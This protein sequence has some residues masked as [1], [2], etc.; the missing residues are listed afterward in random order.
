MQTS[1]YRKPKAIAP[2]P[3]K[4]ENK[5]KATLSVPDLIIRPVEAKKIISTQEYQRA[6]NQRNVMHIKNGY[7]KE[8]VNP[9]KVSLR[10]G[11]YY[12]FDGQHTLAVLTDMFGENCIVPCLVYTGLTYE[13]EAELFAKQDEF[14]RKLSSKEKVKANYEAADDDAVKF[15][16]AVEKAGYKCDF[17]SG[18]MVGTN[19]VGAI[20]YLFNTV[21]KKHGEDYLIRLLSIIRSAWYDEKNATQES[22]IK[23]LDL[24]MTLYDG[25]FVPADL[26][27]KLQK[28]SPIVIIRNGKADMTHSG[29]TRFA[30]AIFDVYN[31]GRK[32]KLRSKF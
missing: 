32:I 12:C 28:V 2:A 7:V 31:K 10:N 1:S 13:Q 3:K 24:F 6:I 4:D 17:H 22:I 27:A 29:A 8:L 18:G 19:K 9:V 23:G 21:Y 16:A 26:V 14:K 25:E 15:V 20:N 30:V 5:N 11:K